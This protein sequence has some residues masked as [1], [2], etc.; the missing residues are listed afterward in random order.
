MGLQIPHI[1][2]RCIQIDEYPLIFSVKILHLTDFYLYQMQ[3]SAF[4]TTEITA[5]ANAITPSVS[6]KDI[7]N[8]NNRHMNAEK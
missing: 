8:G 5:S 3:L 4:V 2:S 1:F 6:P 7:D